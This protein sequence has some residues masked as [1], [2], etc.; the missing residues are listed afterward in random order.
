MLG[1]SSQGSALQAQTEK[2]HDSLSHRHLCL[3]TESGPEQSSDEV[4]LFST[5]SRLGKRKMETYI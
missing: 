5:L 2:Y 4:H 1:C 3:I